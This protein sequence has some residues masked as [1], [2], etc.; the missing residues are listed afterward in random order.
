M[1]LVLLSL[2]GSGL[3]QQAVADDRPPAAQSAAGKPAEAQSAALFKEQIYPLLLRKCAAC[4]GEESQEGRL[5]LD[6]RSTTLAGGI[7]GPAVVTGKPEASLLY[8]R[9]LG[10]GDLDRMP[11]DEEPLTAAQIE[12]VRRWIELGAVWPRDIGPEVTAP[13]K[14]W[15]FIPPKQP[16][17]P[18]VKQTSW[19]HNRIDHFLLARMEQAGMAP[20]PRAGREQLIRRASLHLTG[21]PP[22]LAEIDDFLSDDQPGAF[23]RVVDRLLASPRYGERWAVPWLDAAR[24]ADSNGYQRDGRREAWPWRDWVVAALNADMPFDQFTIEQIAGDLLPG[25]TLL[26]RVATGFHRNT[27]ANVEAGTDPEEEHVLAILDR[28][29]TTGT[30]WLGLSL[31]CASCHNHKYDPISQREYY[32]LYAFFSGTEKEIETNGTERDFIGPKLQVP[33]S[34]EQQQQRDHLQA[35][36]KQKQAERTRLLATL[37][38]QQRNW[39]QNLQLP[40]ERMA[41]V[42]RRGDFLNPGEAV[43]PGTPAVLPPFPAEAPAT[44][45]GLARWLVDPAN[46]L[47]ARVIV[48]RQWA[49]LFGQGLVRTP[50]DFG[51]QGER[52]THPELLDWLAVDFV[53]SGWCLKR[54]HRQMVLSAAWQQSSRITPELRKQDPTNRLL[55]RMQRLRLPAE[56]VRDHVLAVSGLLSQRMEGPPVFPYQ[57]DGVWNHIGRASNL[58]PAST[59]TEKWRRGLYVNWRRTVPYPSFVNFDAPTREQCT[60]QRSQSSTPLQ[61]LTLMNDPAYMEAAVALAARLLN[62]LPAEASDADRVQ[63]GFRLATGRQP[64]AVEMRILVNRV[65]VER[66]EYAEDPQR[67]ELLVKDFPVTGGHAPLALA[68]WVHVASVLLNLDETITRN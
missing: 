24:Y 2:C 21:L 41:R 34:R 44:R 49:A 63:Q 42:F 33:L 37:D 4:H 9:I 3:L 10:D 26:Q 16:A 68:P 31:E 27:M 62:E 65:Q 40:G 7:S 1:M 36:L 56:L 66:T 19:P 29:N 22:S 18:E 57:P 5:R 48:N 13:R 64:S 23:A 47:V 28:V 43:R 58:W 51:I 30:V 52:P 60:V 54:L 39:E 14:H 50:E 20:S 59:G 38:E 6:A 15:A 25:A 46:P 12:V 11:L 61:A 8:Q 67:A 53:R 45:L 55:A 35:E 32:R 17:V